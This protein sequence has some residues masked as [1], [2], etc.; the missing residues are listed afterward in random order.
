MSTSSKTSHVVVVLAD[1]GNVPSQDSAASVKEQ[2]SSAPECSKAA[3]A[4]SSGD[5]ESGRPG[6]EPHSGKS[7]RDC[8]ICH[9]SLAAADREVC[10]A[11]NAPIELGCSCKDDLAAAHQQC[12][13]T[14]FKIR[15]NKTCEI[16]GSVAR[17]VS[18]NCKAELS[19]VDEPV[20]PPP[21]HLVPGPPNFWHGH[22]FLNFV[23]ACVIFAFVISWLFR[24]NVPS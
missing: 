17:N 18:G 3:A 2:R 10:G 20:A 12:A 4:A 24:F 11:D 16:C 9:L 13:E 23:L 22:R 5:L 7:E 6:K 8:R 1:G 14:W 15:G 21:L 19:E